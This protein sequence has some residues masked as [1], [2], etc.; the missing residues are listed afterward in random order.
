MKEVVLGDGSKS[1]NNIPKN[2]DGL[3][4]RK[5]LSFLEQILQIPFITEFSD[6][7][8]II[9]ST[10]NVKTPHDVDM[11]EF[12]EGLYFAL[13]HLFFW[14]I[15]DRPKINNFDGDLFPCAFVDASKDAGT[16][17]FANKIVQ[18]VRIILN[19]L[20]NFVV[21]GGESHSNFLLSSFLIYNINCSI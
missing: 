7:I 14:S 18:T 19:F 12:L 3:I 6:D 1:V 16:E 5:F 9:L 15:P 11:V 17:A 13:K 2:G 21:V 8:A 20:P 4:L 10:V